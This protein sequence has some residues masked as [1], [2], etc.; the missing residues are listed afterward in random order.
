MNKK[1]T[2]LDAI[3]DLRLSAVLILSF[4]LTLFVSCSSDDES[5][6]EQPKP[7]TVHMVFVAGATN[8]VMRGLADFDET[9]TGVKKEMIIR[10]LTVAIFDNTGLAIG[11]YS[12]NMT[13]VTQSVQTIDITTYAATGCTVYAIANAGKDYFADCSTKAMYDAKKTTTLTSAEALGNANETIMFGKVTSVD[14]TA[15]ATIGTIEMEHVCSKVNLVVVPKN[16]D[17]IKVTGWNLYHVP[18]GAFITDSNTSAWTGGF[19]DFTPVTGE[20]ITA[21]QTVATYYLYQNYAGTNASSI[22]ELL[23]NVENAP[24]DAS[25]LTVNAETVAWQ[26]VFRVY[27]GGGKLTE[28]TDDYTDFNVYRN[29]NYTVTVTINGSNTTDVRITHTDIMPI[30]FTATVEALTTDD[31]TITFQ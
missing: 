14:I 24:A 4:C 22:T 13:D 6:G 12:D 2:I 10:N 26:S 1:H 7:V 16:A 30:T 27:L 29:R 18:N 8:N 5:G 9:A 31:R 17:G 15:G 28:T 11:Y 3:E 19:L 25:Y 21:E 23:R 20:K